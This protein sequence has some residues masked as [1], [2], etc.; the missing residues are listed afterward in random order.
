MKKMNFKLLAAFIG[1]LMMVF[2]SCKKDEDD[3][4]A[5]NKYEPVLNTNFEYVVNGNSV[6]F[7]TTITG[8]VWVSS[9]GVDY[10]MVDKTVTVFLPNAG[11]YSFTCSTLG[12]GST[13]TSAA[14]NVVIAQD[15]LS[16]LE[17]GLWKNLTGG[18]NGNKH[19]VLDTSKV[20]FHNPLDFY[21]D[22]EAGGSATNIWGP[23]GGFGVSDPEKGM[24]KFNG[25]TGLA[26]LT[27]DGTDISSSFTMSVYSRDPNFLVLTDASAS[28]LWE[29]MI[30]NKYSYLDS[31]SFQMADLTLTGNV[32]FPLDV[33]RM[34]TEAQFA[35]ND[36]RN[37]KI[38][39]CS[40]SAL[41]IRV[42]RSTEGADKH[43]SK[44]WLLYNYIVHEY[45]YPEP[46][47][48][49]QPVKTGF[50]QADLLGTW[51]FAPVPFDWIG[52]ANADLLNN[53]ADT[54]SMPGWAKDAT[55][56]DCFD[57]EFVFNADGTCT[58][59]G[60][61]NNYTVADGKITFTTALDGTEIKA[62]W[63]NLMGTEVYAIDVKVPEVYDGIWLG[64]RNEDKDESKAVH[65]IKIP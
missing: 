7:T 58:L 39:H 44:C 36:L 24:I 22:P 32:R 57:D 55:L 4:P 18:I 53:W 21:G 2:I 46:V 52:W 54:A 1:A 59:N 10:T 40:D 25:S 26:T 49:A 62:G 61:A 28:T 41:V 17:H 42:K 43:E 6:V 23:W 31:L 14:F 16:F 64:Y 8:N 50:T 11:T 9:N 5:E 37:I 48:L 63:F 20:Y 30:E 65:L 3:P 29:N 34:I 47:V 35:E 12:S 45:D 33:S 38:M 56:K 27:L 60:V 51:K 19:W 13:L 15:D